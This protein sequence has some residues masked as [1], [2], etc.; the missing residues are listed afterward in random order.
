MT[1]IPHSS[2][3]ASLPAKQAVSSVPSFTVYIWA[4]SI[5]HCCGRS[6]QYIPFSITRTCIRPELIIFKQYK[7]TWRNLSN[8]CWKKMKN[9]ITS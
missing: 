9:V 6:A 4:L 8:H 2:D 5:L 1:P 3:S 7:V